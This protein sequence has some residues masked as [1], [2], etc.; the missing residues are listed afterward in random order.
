MESK[1]IVL[2]S[3]ESRFKTE[4]YPPIVLDNDSNHS[5]A[6][7]TLDMYNSIPNIDNSNNEFIYEYN[8]SEYKFNIPEGSYEIND[9]NNYIQRK[10]VENGHDDLF[11]IFANLNTLKCNIEI[12]DISAKIHF[13]HKKSLRHLL[14]FSNGIIEGAQIHESVN[15]VQ[16]H[17]V[18]S[19]LVH[20][21]I[22][23]GSYLNKSQK[24]ILYSFS[25]N[26]PAG[27]K[28]VENPSSPTYLP[29]TVPYI[30]DIRIWLT[31][32]DQNLINHRGEEVTIRLELKS[33]K[34]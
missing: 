17:T 30:E 6:L 7:L 25:P 22:I 34:K 29:V 24:P 12:N 27:Y 15:I 8:N 33:V 28:I 2:S 11:R 1:S 26:V 32:Q 4:F 19:I 21:S 10:L 9:I 5:L 13:D 31:D 16:I 3:N 14:G 23:G 18:N 20:C